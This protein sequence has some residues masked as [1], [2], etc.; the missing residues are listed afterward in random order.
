MTHFSGP[1][2]NKVLELY[3]LIGGHIAQQ[4]NEVSKLPSLETLPDETEVMRFCCQFSAV[5][6]EC[7]KVLFGSATLGPLLIEFFDRGGLKS[8]KVII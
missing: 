7:S 5:F 1:V 3:K 6:S 4:F 8:V 2:D